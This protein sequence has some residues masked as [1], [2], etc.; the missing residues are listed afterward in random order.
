M[1]ALGKLLGEVIE[2]SVFISDLKDT[3]LS[4]VFKG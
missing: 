2:E 4:V 1:I 3:N